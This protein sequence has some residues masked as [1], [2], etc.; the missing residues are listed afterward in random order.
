M[1]V[2]LGY[3][4]L[5]RVHTCCFCCC[6]LYCFFFF[7][8]P[9][10]SFF[11]ISFV[12]DSFVLDRSSFVID[13]SCCHS[14]VFLIPG[15]ILSVCEMVRSNSFIHSFILSFISVH[16]SLPM[17]LIRFFF[18][19]LFRVFLTGFL[20]FSLLRN[21]LLLSIRHR[22]KNNENYT[23]IRS[24]FVCVYVCVFVFYN[25]KKK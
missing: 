17:M 3:I 5:C 11:Y 9:L 24:W 6:C 20:F 23:T 22:E 14:S 25:P 1:C 21:G 13:H 15:I 2:C 4:S 8:T 12:F 10:A 16:Q 7:F 18:S 19:P